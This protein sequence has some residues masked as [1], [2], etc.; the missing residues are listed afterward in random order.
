MSPSPRH[1]SLLTPGAGLCLGLRVRA[2]SLRD[3]LRVHA[4]DGPFFDLF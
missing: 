2:F 4:A 1:S 3:R